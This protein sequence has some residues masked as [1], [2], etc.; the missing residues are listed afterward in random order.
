VEGIL[1]PI[2]GAVRDLAARSE[3]GGDGIESALFGTATNLLRTLLDGTGAVPLESRQ[4]VAWGLEELLAGIAR[5]RPLGIVVEDA[6]LANPEDWSLL[7]DLARRLAPTRVLL[8]IVAATGVAS[9]HLPIPD[10]GILEQ[11]RLGPL[12]AD[13]I[14]RLLHARAGGASVAPEV[15]RRVFEASDGNP[16]FAIE[17]FR[18]LRDS[19]AIARQGDV[20]LPTAGWRT[21]TLPR[22]LHELALARV[23]G[24]PEE[25]RALLDVAAV[26]GVSFDGESVAAGAGRPLLE[27]LRLLQEVYRR[28]GLIVPR[29]NGYRF[30]HAVVQ[31]GIYEEIAPALRRALH[32][33]LAEQLETRAP[34]AGVF[35]ERLGLHW[36]RALEPARA[37][38]H[39]LRAA[40]EALRRQDYLRA[41]D[42]LVRSG[43]HPS[44]LTPDD[45]AA[46]HALLLA[47]TDTYTALGR[48]DDA[49]SV[50]AALLAAA[51]AANDETRRLETLVRRYQKVYRRQGLFGVDEAVLREAA[52]RLPPSEHR[53]RA[54]YL[55]GMIAK[56]RGDLDG[57]HRRF[58]AADGDFGDLPGLHASALDQLGSVSL[59]R[60]RWR[61]AEALYADA[62][63]ISAIVG[64]RSN[65]AVS[66][67]NGA[68]AAYLRGAHE[69]LA[70][71]LDAAIRKL[72]LEGAI[73]QVAGALGLL[74][75]VHYANGEREAARR[76]LDESLR[77]A[78]RAG[79]LTAQLT[80][81]PNRAELL[82]V[83]GRLDEARADLR[84]ARSL[85][86][87]R[88]D[89]KVRLDIAACECRLSAVLGE[90]RQAS[91]SASEVLRLAR[92]A[93]G[94]NPHESS[95]LGI[96]EAGL[97]GLDR[98]SLGGARAFFA[99]RNA[100]AAVA[101]TE[102]VLALADPALP[103]EPLAVAADVLR[104][105]D[106]GPR[107]FALRV[108]A[109]RIGAEAWLRAGD[110]RRARA[111]ADGGVRDAI[112]LG[113]V[114]LEA[115][116]L[117]F[118]ARLEPPEDAASRLARRIDSAASHLS[119]EVERAY[120]LARWR[121]PIA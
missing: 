69:G 29:A 80:S 118:L 38:P 6:H 89:Y 115:C 120:L 32:V 28:T 17:L 19:G 104:R 61:E 5:E 12:D 121:R 60:G 81:L 8:C 108:A 37:R 26:D 2:L 14:S 65:A 34:E 71:R 4:Q 101:V 95:L 117:A 64:R 47:A 111:E 82:F 53:G 78:K 88:E 1:R 97:Y 50:F 119:D 42:L 58:L 86:A 35:P 74:G 87:A 15:G 75:E 90:E 62:A 3:L 109:A 39:L 16:L 57:A 20:L 98:E 63:R 25:Q 30:A 11:V 52:D 103:A 7:C 114:W 94:Q 116:L 27:V 31:E 44:R 107:R 49:E 92:A 83:E 72:T 48:H 18:H 54:N 55:L 41:A 99:E 112:A 22:R 33:R 10:G 70:A 113:H 106:I 24:L 9:A 13:S 96:V 79:S 51:E 102:G 100:K 85:A 45:A 36:E 84:A 68:A 59:R 110:R 73:G 40:W 67:V 76:A 21:A 93:S 77:A 23:A 105:A 66:E 43:L 91:A 56:Y 46:H